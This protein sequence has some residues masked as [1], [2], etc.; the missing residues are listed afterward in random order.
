M[1]G[2]GS[3]PGIFEGW[4]KHF[5]NSHVVAV[6][7]QEGLSVDTATME[8]YATRCVEQGWRVRPPTLLCG[9][10]MGG[11]V[12]MMAAGRL[13]PGWL[14]LL[15]PSPPAEVQGVDETIIPSPGAFD[16]QDVY[17][18]FPS[19]IQARQESSYARAERKRGIS[20][21]TLPHPVLVVYGRD[22]PDERGHR[23]A[24]AY[25]TD[26]LELR[27]LDHWDM[28]LSDRVPAEVSRWAAGTPPGEGPPKTR[29]AWER[30]T[31]SDAA[32]SP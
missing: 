30:V 15:E 16:P 18:S 32:R 12:A 17:G 21:G 8:D 5:P 24:E 22:F 27:G 23:L 26:A 7:L 2:A 19:G 31:D 25:G 6:D 10:S 4:E 29:M 3:G 20:I 11:L 14:A 13:R 1:H 9:W 28:V